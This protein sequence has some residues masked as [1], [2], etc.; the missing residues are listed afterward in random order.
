[1]LA[2]R[3]NRTVSADALIDGLWAE[4]PPESAAKNVQHHV[5]RLR[6]AFAADDCGASIVTHGAAMSSQLS[7]EA[8]DAVRFERLVERARRDADQGIAD[9]AAKEALELWHGAP[10]AD[11]ASE[12]FAG[13]EIRR[14]EELHLRA[15]ELGID[16]E[17][18]AG[19]HGDLIGRLEALIAEHP[20][21][22]RFYAQRMLALYRAGRQSEALEAYRQARRS[23]TDG[24]R[25][26]AR[27]R[28]AP[29]PG[30]DPR[31]G[32]RARRAGAVRGAGAPARGRLA[33]ARRARARAGLAARALGGGPIRSA[34]RWRSSRARPG[35]ARPGS[36]PSSRPSAPQPGQRSLRRRLGGGGAGA[37]RGPPRG[38]ERAARRCSSSTTPTMLRPRRS[39][40]RRL[41]RRE[42]AR[43]APAHPRPPPGRAEPAGAGGPRARRR[44]AAPGP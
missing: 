39:R 32:P 41:A 24:A 20:L 40:P 29:P 12:P 15:L 16:A 35:S 30:A 26:R 5:S 18:A 1:M 19:R 14:L 7:E 2:L 8:V 23:L 44:I 13:P 21:N 17:L 9:G 34:Q 10:L 27:A 38:R 3:A 36:P 31:P 6:K 37:G 4:R 42:A 25:D 43:A 28:A 11:V 33:P 22:E